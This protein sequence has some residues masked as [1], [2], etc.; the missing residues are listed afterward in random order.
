MPGLDL[1]PAI[2]GETIQI[3]GANGDTIEPAF[4]QPGQWRE[5]LDQRIRLIRGRLVVR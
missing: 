4:R 3:S 5:G 1:H 2:S